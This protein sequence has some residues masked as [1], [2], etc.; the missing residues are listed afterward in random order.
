MV[1]VTIALGIGVNLGIFTI[2]NAM[3]L[4]LLSVPD[5]DQ[6]VYYTLGTGGDT[7]V[8]FSI[9]QYQA[10]RTNAA[11]NDILAWQPMMLELRGPTEDIVLSGALVTGNT[12]SVLR[13]RPFLGRFFNESDDVEGGG[14]NGWTAVL[15]YSY[16]KAHWAANPN[17]IGRAV[18][19]NGASVQIVGVLPRDF[20]GVE[21]FKKV[22]ILVPRQFETVTDR[23]RLSLSPPGAVYLS[24][25][26]L[27]R[28][29]TGISIQQVQ[30]NLKTIEPSFL[31]AAL[32]WGLVVVF[33]PNTA[34]GSLLGV[35][36]GR[37]GVTPFRTVRDPLLMLQ[38]L[39]GAVLLFCCCN[40]ILLF[41]SRAR[42]E[43]H[44]TAI[45]L[46]LGARLGD[47]ARLATVEAAVLGGFGCLIAVPVA[48]SAARLL[49]LVIQ[50]TPGFDK[51]PSVGT[52]Y[53]L[54]L[55]ALGITL[56]AGGLSAAG[57]SLWIGAKR[58]S[59]SLRETNHTVAARSRNW[60]IGLEVSVAITLV[61]AAI[62]SFVGF[63]TLSNQSGFDGKAVMAELKGGMFNPELN[64]ILSRIPG[65]PGV[66]AVATS[67]VLPLSRSR[68]MET[69][70]AYS[71]RGG[72]RELNVWSVGVSVP[73][74]SAI[75]TK[76]VGGRD[77]QPDDMA[78]QA[79]CI[80]SSN[81]ASA[82]FPEEEP[83]GKYLR[84]P[85]C[86][87]IGIAED[88]HFLSMSAPPDAVMYDLLRKP[89]PRIIVKAATSG[90]AIQAVRNAGQDEFASIE[91]IEVSVDRDLRLWKVVMISGMLCTLLAGTIL[92][93]GFLGI[94]SL[95]VAER[96][97]EIG[98]RIALG[99]SLA[100]VSF[101][102]LTKLGPAVAVGL[103][104]G[105][106]GA[107]LAGAKLTELYQ[108]SAPR[109]IACY[110]ASLVLLGF[111]L[112]AAAAVP[113]S[114]AFAISLVDCLS[115]E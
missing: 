100:R 33:F 34:P 108:L 44:A 23:L 55:I 115:T 48:W 17:V 68:S 46:V 63:Q 3:F 96:Q 97:R 70:E 85:A 32:P 94:L 88:A 12:F 41:I 67:S 49:S 93:V 90:L 95:Q 52:D 9:Q 73:Y 62:I 14:K 20:T 22:D 37:M 47:Q 75:G 11:A 19:L 89:W 28:L 110:L 84:D 83:V 65:S 18:N 31:Q 35:H 78:G 91:P 112:L 102:L 43:A 98:I 71:S 105:S 113:L 56:A 45:R 101:A 109:V 30:A 111:L 40:L 80:L 5:A 42:R 74:F 39:A 104:L 54:L 106:A 13:L 114:R 77:F 51:F 64:R 57:T 50:S 82:L 72:V 36:D 59:V 38:G 99:G 86:R 53:F 76:I 10:L 87:V 16:W 29:P 26:V 25:F 27:G 24:W 79:V 15:G 92:A 69:V 66:Q 58:A 8:K 61:T 107:F 81:A 4:N 60:I 1:I 21:P 2:I 6:V 103:A 7:Q